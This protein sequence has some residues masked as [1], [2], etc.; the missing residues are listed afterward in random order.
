[1]L[2]VSLPRER[3]IRRSGWLFLS[4]RHAGG[5]AHRSA[6]DHMHIAVVSLGDGGQNPGRDSGFAPSGKAVVAA[7]ARARTPSAMP[8]MARPFSVPRDPIQNPTIADSRN[9]AWVC[10]AATA[11]SP[12][13]R[14]PS[15]HNPAPIQPPVGKL[16]SHLTAQGN[17]VYGFTT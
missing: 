7:R 13:I 4:W 11:R 16:E 2:V 1:M 3:P 9:P 5:N 10:S 12:S 6:I 8:A 15:A 17:P 14:S